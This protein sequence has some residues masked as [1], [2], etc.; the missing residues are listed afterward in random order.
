MNVFAAGSFPDR[1]CM[2]MSDGSFWCALVLIVIP[3][4]SGSGRIVVLSYSV[5]CGGMCWFRVSIVLMAA[6]IVSTV[7]CWCGIGF[8]VCVLM[9]RWLQVDGCCGGIGGVGC[10]FLYLGGRP[11]FFFGGSSV[12]G[13]PSYSMVMSGSCW[14]SWCWLCLTVVVFL[15]VVMVFFV[16]VFPKHARRGMIDFL[17][18]CAF[19]FS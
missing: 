8:G 14:L 10:V 15:C 12:V 4:K 16:G 13:P 6:R 3:S 18:G 11:L 2:Y 5:L 7:G 1:S 17:L 9:L 19:R